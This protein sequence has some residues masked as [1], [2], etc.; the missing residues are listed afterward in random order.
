M[1]QLRSQEAFELPGFL[2]S[3][4]N[5]KLVSHIMQ[6]DKDQVFPRPY[7]TGILLGWAP[8]SFMELGMGRPITLGGQGRPAVRPLDIPIVLFTDTSNQNRPTIRRLG[9]DSP[10]APYIA[11]MT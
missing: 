3:L 11:F 5:S 2:R 1:V 4:G 9:P 8:F 10:L 7:V 6:L